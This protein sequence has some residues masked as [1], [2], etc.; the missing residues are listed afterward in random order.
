MPQLSEVLG[1]ECGLW[2]ASHGEHWQDYESA[3]PHARRTQRAFT[4]S[5]ANVCVISPGRWLRLLT[6]ATYNEHQ[7]RARGYLVPVA[8]LSGG[9]VR[10]HSEQT[11]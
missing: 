6:L 3:E 5:K 2:P 9:R 1:H 11:C 4:A 7:P 10:R 8:D